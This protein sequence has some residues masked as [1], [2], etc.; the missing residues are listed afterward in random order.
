M[1]SSSF[2]ALF[3]IALCAGLLTRLWLANR[4]RRHVAAHRDAV[5]AA[6]TGSISLESHQKAADYTVARV[7]TGMLD[8]LISVALL[9]ALTFGGVLQQSVEV[10]LQRQLR[11]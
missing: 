5:P 7:R 10:G 3:L 1:T 11:A 8:M 4:H 6:F 2:S 9:L